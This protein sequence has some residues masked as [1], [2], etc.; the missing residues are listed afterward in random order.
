MYNILYIKYKMNNPFF[1]YCINYCIF[2]IFYPGI[3][4][5]VT[6]YFLDK[7]NKTENNE[8]DW[9][10]L[11]ASKGTWKLFEKSNKIYCP[12]CGKGFQTKTALLQHTDMKH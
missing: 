10:K 8:E 12:I 6:K 4:L 3:T 7:K 1:I 2:F 9:D 5:K 11:P